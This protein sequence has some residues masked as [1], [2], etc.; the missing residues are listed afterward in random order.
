MT[1]KTS[2]PDGKSNLE[3]D[4]TL[5]LQVI[6]EDEL[7]Y[8]AEADPDAGSG[9]SHDELRAFMDEPIEPADTDTGQEA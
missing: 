2:N 3:S 4:Y 8:S 1:Y 7:D 5:A 6:E 9:F